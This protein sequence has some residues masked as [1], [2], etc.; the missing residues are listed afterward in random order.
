MATDKTE[1]TADVETEVASAPDSDASEDVLLI[2]AG[3]I[4]LDSVFVSR[5]FSKQPEANNSR[6]LNG[7]LRPATALAR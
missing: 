6:Q 4:L 5:E 1:E 3:Q 7:H 2:E